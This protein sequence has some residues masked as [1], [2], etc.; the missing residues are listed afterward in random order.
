M[1]DDQTD[2]GGA[3]SPGGHR[4]IEVRLDDQVGDEPDPERWRRLVLDTLRR[5]EVTGGSLDV[6]F[7]DA[8]TIADLNAEHLGKDGPT[9][10]LSFPLDDPND[11]EDPVFGFE[12]PHLGDV[13]LCR[14]VAIAQAPGHAGSV[15]AEL[16]L[17]LVH[18]V[19]HIL[20]H[21]HAE[22]DER[23]TMQA[24]ERVHLTAAGYEHP[25]PA[26]SPASDLAPVEE[27]AD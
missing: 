23:E 6:L 11:V 16:T 15:D 2:A 7:V 13:V 19:L 14:E 26:A 9:D 10:V 22:D 5:E 27:S 12:P 3:E 1:N 8:A 20:G 21:D 18:G 25:V 4:E 17:L 24:R